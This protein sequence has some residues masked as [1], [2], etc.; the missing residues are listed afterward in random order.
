MFGVLCL[1]GNA[2]YAL[3]GGSDPLLVLGELLVAGGLAMPRDTV[4]KRYAGLAV[5]SAGISLAILMR[6]TGVF[7]LVA[8][9]L[10]LL[11]ETTIRRAWREFAPPLIALAVPAA[12]FAALVL[13]N[14]TL[15]G[16]VTGG[17]DSGERAPVLSVVVGALSAASHATG[18]ELGSPLGPIGLSALAIASV[19]IVIRGTVMVGTIREH[20]QGE[21]RFGSLQRVCCF[22][23]LYAIVT[24]CTLIVLALGRGGDAIVARYM[25]PLLPMLIVM[26]VA[27]VCARSGEVNVKKDTWTSAFLFTALLLLIIGQF[28]YAGSHIRYLQRDEAIA[29]VEAALG[30]EFR[31]APLR[32]CLDG[33]RSSCRILS[34]SAQLV[35]GLTGAEVLGLAPYGYSKHLWT[36]DEVRQLVDAYRVRYV[37][38]HASDSDARGAPGRQFFTDLRS[39]KVPDWLCPVSSS[40]R[41][42]IFEVVEAKA[43]LSNTAVNRGDSS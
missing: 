41:V 4:R 1:T 6:Y 38:L 19:V 7:L 21:R 9:G 37:L 28:N 29:G 8:A 36:T 35:G 31:S 24:F 3:R 15:V 25:M 43:P 22:T 17:I 33:P 27:L 34:S 13:R 20:S 23:L 39:R 40:E 11:L 30:A 16:N 32:D 12:I 26:G 10:V 2:Y 42:Q 5:I 14:L 18:Y